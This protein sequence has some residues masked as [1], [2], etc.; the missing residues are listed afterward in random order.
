MYIFSSAGMTIT[1]NWGSLLVSP[2]LSYLYTEQI[3]FSFKDFPQEV[4]VAI[5]KDASD[6]TI[7]RR[8]DSIVKSL[9]TEFGLV[10]ICMM[11]RAG[12]STVLTNLLFSD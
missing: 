8:N 11:Y 7:L 2:I 3:F 12:R 9:R 1:L 6:A 10:V 5:Y 4:K